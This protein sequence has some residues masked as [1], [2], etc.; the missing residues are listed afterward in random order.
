MAKEMRFGEAGSKINVESVFHVIFS[1]YLKPL[2]IERWTVGSF[3]LQ[4]GSHS[5]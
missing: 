4:F 3:K 1:T 5:R 2:R